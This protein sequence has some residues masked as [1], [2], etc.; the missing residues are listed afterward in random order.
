M[1]MLFSVGPAP[2][3]WVSRA[4]GGKRATRRSGGRLG[5]WL[6]DV[7]ERDAARILIGMRDVRQRD[8]AD[9]PLIAAHERQTPDLVLRH[10]VGGILD[11][12]ILAAGDDARAG[13]VGD[14]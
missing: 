14:G 9:Q 5:G 6:G 3:V 12:G 11:A 13:D 8:D 4:P 10:Q 1:A 2:A 7:V